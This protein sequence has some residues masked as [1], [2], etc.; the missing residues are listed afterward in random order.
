MSYRSQSHGIASSQ[1][2]WICTLCFIENEKI[3]KKEIPQ[4]KEQRMNH[5]FHQDTPSTVYDGQWTDNYICT[6]T[7]T[8][9]YQT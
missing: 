9:Q 3:R 1:Q 2:S 5:L 6:G 8:T 4:R 7:K